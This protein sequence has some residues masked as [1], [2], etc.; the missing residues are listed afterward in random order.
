MRFITIFISLWSYVCLV[1]CQP[2][3]DARFLTNHD[4]QA[5]IGG[6]P[7]TT[8]QYPFVVNIWL[9]SPEDFFVGHLCGASLIHSHWVL[10]AAHCLLQD[11]TDKTQG[12]LKT[13]EMTLFLGSLQSTGQGGTSLKAK[14]VLIHPQFNWPAYDVA[15]IELTDDVK[16]V[17]PVRLASSDIHF[18]ENQ[19]MAT[20]VGW[21]LIDEQ[22]HTESKVLR[23]VTLPLVSTESCAQ[24]PYV[25]KRKWPLGIET[26][27]ARTQMGTVAS[28]HG[29]SGGPLFQNLDGNFVQ[30]GIVS[31]G[32]ACNLADQGNQADVEGYSNV[33]AAFPWIQSQVGL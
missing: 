1:A 24:D 21:G 31:W 27:C 32:S 28:C 14:R 2:S 22:G 5:I 11:V 7:V 29:D 33:A 13:Q 10:T 15:L 3:H 9:N 30:I 20:V 17:N 12:T 19:G 16:E 8:N 6:Q 26:I 23:A 4:S 25:Q 18:I